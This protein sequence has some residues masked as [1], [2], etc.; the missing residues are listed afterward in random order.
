ML[1]QLGCGGSVVKELRLLKKQ[2]SK[3]SSSNILAKNRSILSSDI[4]KLQCWAEHFAEVCNCC[5]SSCQ[6]DTDA[7]PDIIAA[8]PSYTELFPDDENLSQPISEDEIQVAIA[9]LRDGKAPGDDGI[10]AELLKLAGDETICWLTSLFN[11]IW[12]SESIPSDWLN[13]LIVPLHKKGS[14]SKCDNYRGIALL[15]IPSKIFTRFILNR[16]KPRADRPLA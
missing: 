12:S 8:T 5:S 1:Q 4:D 7:L 11:F 13:H 6:L 15:S 3:P 10:S 16:I 9:Q 14:R 2:A